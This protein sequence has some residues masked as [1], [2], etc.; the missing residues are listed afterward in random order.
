MPPPDGP[1][2]GSH[3]NPYYGLFTLAK[4]VKKDLWGFLFVFFAYGITAL[5]NVGFAE[6]VQRLEEAFYDDQSIWRWYAPLAMVGLT[7]IRGLSY[8]LGTYVSQYVSTSISYRLTVRMYQHLI[9]LPQTFFDRSS[10]GEVMSKITYNIGNIVSAINQGIM[11]LLREGLSFLVLLIYLFY[12]NWSLTLIIG[13]ILPILLL[14]LK[15]ARDRLRVLSRRLQ[16]NAAMISRMMVEAFGALKLV[17]ASAMES[18][19]VA[20]FR[21]QVSYGRK[22]SLKVAF[23]NAITVPSLQF[24]VSIAF[25]TIIFIALN[26]E[27]SGFDSVGQFLAYLTAAGFLANPLRTL[28]NVQKAIQ[29]GEIGARDYVHHLSL[30]YEEDK[31][32]V[33]LQ[34]EKVKGAIHFAKVSFAYEE[35]KPVFNDLSLRIKTQEK[36]ALV[37]QSG[38]G[39]STLVNLLL[40]FYLPNKGNIFLDGNNLRDINLASLRSS[41]AYVSQDIFLF[42]ESLRYNLTY[43]LRDNRSDKQIRATLA[44]AHAEDFVDE[45]PNGLDTILGERGL[46][47]SG[48]QKQRVSLA[49]ALLKDAPLLILDEATSSLDT[50]SE[51]RIQRMLESIIENKTVVVI[52]HRLSTIKKVDRIIV[53]RQGQV[54]EEGNHKKLLAKSGVYTRLYEHQFRD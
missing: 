47:L 18:S 25:A 7:V 2:E 54:I 45:M 6:V 38:A 12:L 51:Y 49:R 29:A 28:G 26:R 32:T 1:A 8:A 35:G 42:N 41:I 53:L 22:Q 13:L 31:G 52:A 9:K 40:R 30:D 16:K 36:L 19:E 10:V 20:R 44:H 33:I 5:S 39:K 11:I 15:I 48:G 46:I 34:R 14:L 50:E 3:R 27:A 21:R 4:Q 37:G 23:V 24:F 17:R 43:G